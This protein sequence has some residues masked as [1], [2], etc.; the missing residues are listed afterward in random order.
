MDVNPPLLM[1]AETPHGLR[2]K[3]F[4]DFTPVMDGDWCRWLRLTC[5]RVILTAADGGEGALMY[6][7]GVKL[8]HGDEWSNPRLPSTATVNDKLHTCLS[9]FDERRAAGVPCVRSC[10][11]A[12]RVGRGRLQRKLGKA[13][14]YNLSLALPTHVS[15]ASHAAQTHTSCHHP[16]DAALSCF[17]APSPS[18]SPSPVTRDRGPGLPRAAI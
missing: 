8:Y 5:A 6:G 15:T 14:C 18:P 10:T 2:Q 16:A 17:I 4:F 1:Y 3:L 13:F 12:R 9:L 11:G 7:A